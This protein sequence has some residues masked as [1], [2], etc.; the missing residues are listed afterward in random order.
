LER[1]KN[2]EVKMTERIDWRK[3]IDDYF[4]SR[5]YGSENTELKMI[6]LITRLELQHKAEI[7]ELKSDWTASEITKCANC[8]GKFQ[9]EIESLKEKS[10]DEAVAINNTIYDFEKMGSWRYDS[11]AVNSFVAKLKSILKSDKREG[12]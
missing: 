7:G 6:D 10:K 5:K 1:I 9:N 3:E 4:G 11:D 12:E 8:V 2:K